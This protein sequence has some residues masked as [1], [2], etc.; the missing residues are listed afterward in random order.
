M[1]AP[2]SCLW[3]YL[4]EGGGRTVSRSLRDAELLDRTS[5][6]FGRKML[7]AGPK[8]GAGHVGR[9]AGVN[10][11]QVALPEP[12]SPGLNRPAA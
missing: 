2:P 9:R 10:L 4:R 1:N 5:A 6:E 12:L 3:D 8:F 7:S 11:L